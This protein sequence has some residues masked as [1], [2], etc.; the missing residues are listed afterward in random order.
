[1]PESATEPAWICG[2]ST[3]NFAGPAARVRVEDRV[4][5]ARQRLVPSDPQPAP[6]AP[7]ADAAHG[8]EQPIGARERVVEAAALLAALR[9]EVRVF[10]AARLGGRALLL[11]PD[12]A[13]ARVD[14]EGAAARET[15]IGVGA[16][17]D[18]IPAPLA[19]GRR[20]P[21][22]RRRGPCL[23]RG[24]CAGRAAEREGRAAASRARARGRRRASGMAATIEGE[25]AG[26]AARH[27]RAAAAFAQRAVA[28][29]A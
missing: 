12:D 15:L 20:P 27:A 16:P 21:R 29:R 1:M 11:A 26:F 17:G 4:G 10:R 28:V 9:V 7:G 18:A 13:A 6:L 24:R 3:M 14:V 2:A 19:R 8:V 5:D 25:R 23:Q 22:R